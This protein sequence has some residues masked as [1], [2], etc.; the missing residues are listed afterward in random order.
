MKLFHQPIS[1]IS[2]VERITKNKI[3]ENSPLK[4]LQFT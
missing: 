4:R 3:H 1:N 2:L